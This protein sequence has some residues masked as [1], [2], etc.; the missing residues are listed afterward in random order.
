M[1]WRDLID[2]GRHSEVA[3]LDRSRAAESLLKRRIASPEF[4]IVNYTHD[5]HFPSGHKLDSF[6]VMASSQN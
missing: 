2:A 4:V 6:I 1:S 3:D 5:N